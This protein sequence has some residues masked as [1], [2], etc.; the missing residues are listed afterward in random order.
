MMLQ[1]SKPRHQPTTP[2][3]ICS[4]SFAEMRD[5]LLD[6][7]SFICGGALL[8]L[9]MMAS[10]CTA[11]DTRADSPIADASP[12]TATRLE[13]LGDDGYP[14]A[15]ELG[16]TFADPLVEDLDFEPLV[17]PEEGGT[18]VATPFYSLYV[19]D[20]MF[21]D[22]WT[23]DYSGYMMNWGS[24][25]GKELWMGHGLTVT[26]WNGDYDAAVGARVTSANW[27][28][29]QG[30]LVAIS[31]GPVPENERFQ[32][33]VHGPADYNTDKDGVRSRKALAHR[34]DL[35]SPYIVAARNETGTWQ[36]V[37]VE[38]PL[39]EVS[40]EGGRTVLS[41]PWYSVALD[42]ELWPNGCT[43][44]YNGKIERHSDDSG[45]SDISRFLELYDT[46]TQD[47]VG[48]V[49]LCSDAGTG[50]L[51][52][53]RGGYYAWQNMGPSPCEPEQYVCVGVPTG[54]AQPI[55]VAEDLDALQEAARPRLERLA[56]CVTPA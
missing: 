56:A 4:A 47:L 52:E 38:Q 48:I 10:G 21:P 12:V 46:A 7:R 33:V 36:I 50:R 20:D 35:V 31:V 55:G 8:A 51:R 24:D 45:T 40:A 54:T 44:R 49:C 5:R 15:E 39:P 16:C 34:A 23:L 17:A 19:P 3:G 9:S 1:T 18:R 28:G 37:K 6:R 27:D 11:T 25:I 53:S 13:P 32:T 43:Y 26:S 14:S 2:R 29:I 22:G 41:V 30:E 42:A